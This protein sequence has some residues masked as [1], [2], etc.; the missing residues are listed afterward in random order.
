MTNPTGKTGELPTKKSP[1]GYATT[2]APLEPGPHV[3]NV[4]F[5]NQEVPKSPFNVN[6]EPKPNVGA[7]TVK[8]LETRK[9]GP[10]A[11]CCIC[12]DVASCRLYI[13]SRDMK[14]ACNTF[15]ENDVL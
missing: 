9:S 8:G 7:V 5:A 4:K 10:R 2:F 15:T 3:V 14:E 12:I 11:S 6:V 1:E 13:G